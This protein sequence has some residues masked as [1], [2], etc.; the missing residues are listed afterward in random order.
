[1]DTRHRVLRN[2]VCTL[3]VQERNVVIPD[4]TYENT[5][6]AALN[7]LRH[8]P[9]ILKSFPAELKRQPLLRVHGDRLTGRNGK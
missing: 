8:D 1:M 5:G 2:T 4:C 7:C 6:P 3:A 9:R